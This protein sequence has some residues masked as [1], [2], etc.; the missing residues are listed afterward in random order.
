[1]ASGIVMAAATAQV[2]GKTSFTM[3]GITPEPFKGK[4]STSFNQARKEEVL[5]HETNIHR[6]TYDNATCTVS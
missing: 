4:I 1:V 3:L 2:S 6:Y 5:H